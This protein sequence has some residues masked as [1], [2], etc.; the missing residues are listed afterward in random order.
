[1]M[2]LKIH[3]LYK[4]T[5]VI[6]GN[7]YIGMHSTSNINDGYLGSGLRLI[8]SVSKYGAE[9]FTKEILE[10]CDSREILAKREFDVIDESVVNHPLC[11]N[12]RRGGQGGF[13]SDQQKINNKKAQVVLKQLREN[14]LDWVTH[15]SQLLSQSMKEQYTTGIRTVKCKAHIPGEYKHSDEARQ[16][17]SKNKGS[18]VGDKNP[19]AKPVID[20]EGNTFTT[21]KECAKFH[22]IHPDT[23]TRRIKNG[24][25]TTLE[26]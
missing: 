8:R 17:I 5:N 7:F 20:N 3:Y 26:V 24:L 13:T 14:D 21:Y 15:K 4:V 19:S 1:M 12:L 11:M 9:N 6:T 2:K 22:S 23:V 16:K 25:Y 10:Y 18:V